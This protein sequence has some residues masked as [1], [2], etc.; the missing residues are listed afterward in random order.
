[1]NVTADGFEVKRHNKVPPV[2]LSFWIV[3]I[4]STTVGE[5]VA[6]SLAVDLGLGLYKTSIACLAI[7]TFLLFWQ[8]RSR[9]YVPSLYWPVVVLVSIVGTQLTDILTDKLD[10]SLR[11]SSAAFAVLLTS[12][13]LIWQRVEGTLAIESIN[14]PR[15]EAFYWAAILCTFALGT[16]GG[17]LATE[18]FGIG[19]RLGSLVFMGAIACVS[20]AY[21]LGAN[22]ILAFWTAYILTRP[23]GAALGDLLSQS[24]EFGGLGFGAKATSL[25]F[26]SVILVF[27]VIEQRSFR[28]GVQ[29]RTSLPIHP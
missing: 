21:R 29:E 15:R 1:M 28:G 7:L 16:A 5:T 9:R 6:D 3:K 26:L 2:L 24:R 14:T 20:V 25:V 12:M 17:D 19:F 13:F 27:V 11:L 4:L 23:L 8:F 18:D 22:R 10:V